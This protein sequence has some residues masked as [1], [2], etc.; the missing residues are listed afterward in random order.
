MKLSKNTG[1]TLI[2]L[3]V[4]LAILAIVTAIAIPTYTDYVTAGRQTECNN[5]VA[6]IQLAEEEF[7]LEN[8]T[9]FLGADVAT[10]ET[11]SQG[12]YNSSYPN[13]AAI[14]AADCSYAVAAGTT[15]NINS[16]YQVTATGQNNLAGLG[17]IV[18][19]GN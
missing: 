6:R 7:F 14:A 18:Q 4:T 19:N 2:E 11:N 9:Y 5:E 8:N 12:I 17:V 13:A 15:G 10:L 16:S 3:M 1:I